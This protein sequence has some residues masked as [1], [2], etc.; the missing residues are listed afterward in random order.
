[1]TEVH[2][3]PITQ[4]N[5]NVLLHNASQRILGACLQKEHTLKELVEELHMDMS[6]AHYRVQQLIKAGILKVSREEKRAGRPIK[7]YAPTQEKFFLPFKDTVYNTVVDFVVQQMEPIL[8]RFVE[9][10]FKNVPQVG[11][12]GLTFRPD[13][14][15]HKL[16]TM[17]HQEGKNP[18][19]LGARDMQLKHRVLAMWQTL[20]LLP[21]DARDMQREM[22]DLYE[23]YRQKQNPGGEKHIIGMFLTAG[24][25]QDD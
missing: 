3:K 11:E 14:D 18:E 15:G 12:W 13:Q 5:C 19:G 8:H 20:D 21:D 1:M 4:L 16:S 2:E 22:M 10:I 7:Y 9:L 24:D 25:L 6:E 23:K 17:F